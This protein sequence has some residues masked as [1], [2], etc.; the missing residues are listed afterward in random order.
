MIEDILGEDE[1]CHR[2][3]NTIRLAETTCHDVTLLQSGEQPT[4]VSYTCADTINRYTSE[5]S[6]FGKTAATLDKAVKSKLQDNVFSGISNFW[7]WRASWEAPMK[8]VRVVGEFTKQA[9]TNARKTRFTQLSNQVGENIVVTIKGSN[10]DP[11]IQIK[12][13]PKPIVQ[14]DRLITRGTTCFEI[15]DK[16]SV[17]KYAWTSVKGYSEVDFLK[18]ALPVRGVVNYLTS[19]EVYWTSKLLGNLDFF[20][21]EAWDLKTETWIISSG[22]HLMQPTLSP[23]DR[24]RK[25]IRIAFTPCG[26]PL[27]TSKTILDFVVRIWD[28]ILGHRRLY[29]GGILHGDISEGNIILTSPTADDESKGMLID[30]DYSVGRIEI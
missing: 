11:T 1:L 9:D 23:W 7:N 25:L 12:I 29:N 8:D 2:L 15:V 27:K 21:A 10:D 22:T 19:D 26:Q 18:V 30:L 20:D 28:A 14:P 6:G 17:V 24:D 5:A 13:D 4:S 16:L 3:E